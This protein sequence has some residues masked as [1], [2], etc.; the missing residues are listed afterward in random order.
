MEV[1]VVDNEQDGAE[2]VADTICNL[3]AKAPTTVLGLATGSTPSATYAE[4]CKR[5]EFGLDF[6][7][8]TVFMLDEFLGLEPDDDSLY[9]NSIRSWFTDPVGIPREQVHAPD[10]CTQDIARECKEYEE[11]IRAAG[12]VDLQLLGIGRDGHIAFN[13]PTS[14]LGSRTR[15]K[16]LTDQSRWDNAEGFNARQAASQALASSID[17]ETRSTW[18]PDPEQVP[19]HVITQG[20]GTILEAKH[21]ILLANGSHKSDAIAATVEGPITSM[22]PA[23]A[24]Q[25]HPH[26][27]VVVDQQ[28]AA[29]L[30]LI[31]Y[32]Q[33]IH[34]AKIHLQPR[35]T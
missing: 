20:I 31:D 19:L 6:S 26:A 13:E 5:S 33:A 32:Y 30:Q 24:L 16:T 9:L 28:A 25:M 22:V 23:T 35:I 29:K 4:L 1:I 21:L 14:S 12:G 27:T 34:A 11:K 17:E 3:V 10:S 15:V 18:Q 8:T 7:R 2:L